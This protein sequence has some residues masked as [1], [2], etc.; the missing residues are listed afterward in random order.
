MRVQKNGVEIAAAR[1]GVKEWVW[2]HLAK[3]LTRTAAAQQQQPTLTLAY[4]RASPFGDEEVRRMSTDQAGDGTDTGD[5][6]QPAPAQI[7]QPV[8]AAPA[9]EQSPADSPPAAPPPEPPTVNKWTA[10]QRK[11]AL[12]QAV[13]G[14]V[15]S[16]WKV[17]SQSDFQ[18]VMIQEGT[19]VNHILHLIL[20]ILTAGLWAIVWIILVLTRKKE[21]LEVINVDEYGHTNIER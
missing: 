20:T 10:D 8:A 15:R 5:T 9:E 16:G 17:Q 13:A 14:E 21:K 7:D 6:E 4:T 18:G 11:Q 19:K 3:K 1:A 2:A 12:A